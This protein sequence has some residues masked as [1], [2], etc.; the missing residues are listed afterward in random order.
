MKF[1]IKDVI[2]VMAKELHIKP[3]KAMKTFNSA[4]GNLTHKLSQVILSAA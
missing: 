2:K 4:N 3:K 1:H